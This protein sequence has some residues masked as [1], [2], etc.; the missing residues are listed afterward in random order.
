MEAQ[1]PAEADDGG[2]TCPE[3]LSNAPAFDHRDCIDTLQEANDALA[4]K[5]LPAD[6]A[7]IERLRAALETAQQLATEYR[8]RA[9]GAEGLA[10]GAEPLPWE[11]GGHRGR[12]FKHGGKRV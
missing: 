8:D 2:W 11:Q 5:S 1:A 9:T 4:E 10:V 6:T 3:C 7:E 12:S